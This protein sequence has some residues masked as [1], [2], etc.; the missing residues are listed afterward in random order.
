MKKIF[1]TGFPGF[2]GTRLVRELLKRDSGLEVIA[3]IQKKFLQAAEAARSRFF[4]D[5][6]EG[7]ARLQFVLGDI[8]EENLG[9]SE[10]KSFVG[11]INAIFH[12]AA[13]YDLEVSRQVGM[14]VNVEGTKNIVEFARKCT[15]LKRLDYVS[16]AYVSGNLT[17]DFSENDFDRGQ[18]FKNFYEETKF[19]AEKTIRD[20]K[21]IPSV[22][23]RPGIIV[24]DSK[25]GEISKYDGPYYVLQTMLA[26]PS[27]FPF[28]RIGDGNAEVNLVP[29]DFVIAALASL[30][31][32]NGTLNNT[33]HLTDP[34]PLNV[35]ELQTRF[36]RS[37]GK[38][39]IYF[40][41]PPTVAREAMKIDLL[42]KV[43]RMPAQLVDYFVQQ[44][45]YES[46]QTTAALKKLG[47]VC[48]SI[49]GYL[50]NLVSFFQA[51]RRD[52]LQGILI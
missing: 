44:I 2:I 35:R 7:S 43:Y 8:T 19:L 31:V 18:K 39:F 48:P 11:D 47:V 23:Y 26:L 34:L 12:L 9:L 50:N 27:F 46:T 42:R 36:A 30:S 16:T 51:H 49:S 41:M 32:E 13:A 4:E 24:G 20:A 40:P 37:L 10:S 33:Y 6:P 3:L 29:I 21:E 25:T 15:N 1:F 22:I 52:E 17:G 28:P 45:H 5:F 38:R 14:R